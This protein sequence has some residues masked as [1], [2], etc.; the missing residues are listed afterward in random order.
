MCPGVKPSEKILGT[1]SLPI[2]CF[3][4]GQILLLI[5]YLILHVY[6]NPIDRKS[7]NRCDVTSKFPTK[8][9]VRTQPTSF[10]TGIIDLLK[11]HKVLLQIIL[12]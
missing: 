2:Y 1:M 7:L 12:D 3:T 9:Q 5:K 10:M 8:L 4:N 6:K 11:P